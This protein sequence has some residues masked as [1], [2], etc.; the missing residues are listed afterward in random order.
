[1]SAADRCLLAS[2]FLDGRTLLE[3]A[4]LLRVHEATI[5]RRIK[6][7][8]EELRKQLMRNLQ[9]GGLSHRAAE[10]A[11]GTDPR[12]VEINLKGMLQGSQVEAFKGQGWQEEGSTTETDS[13]RE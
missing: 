9:A 2:Y 6:R 1:L 12:D 7:L 5:S 3:I 13:P 4:R 10:E 11:L 8:T